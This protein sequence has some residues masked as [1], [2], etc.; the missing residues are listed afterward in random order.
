MA[1][2]IQ[3]PLTRLYVFQK[4]RFGIRMFFL[5][6]QPLDKGLDCA[7]DPNTAA[8]L[9]RPFCD[10]PLQSGDSVEGC[11]QESAVCAEKG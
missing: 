3:G 8:R 2:G 11:A 10:S 4:E 6:A 1:E 9:Q 7:G 5:S